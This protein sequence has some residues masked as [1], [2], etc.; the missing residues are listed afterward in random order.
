MGFDRQSARTGH[1][2]AADGSAIGS[3]RAEELLLSSCALCLV[4]PLPAFYVLTRERGFVSVILIQII[5]SF[6]L[7]LFSGPGPAAIAEI[8]P[9]RGRSTWMSS[10]YAL[11]VAIFGAFAPFVSQWLI[12]ATGSKMA[13][14]AYVMAAAAVS[15]VTIAGLQETAHQPLR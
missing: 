1:P 14:A 3:D 13:P 10:S 6:A 2:R 7:S 5:F 11:A 9:T 15:F 4:L 12:D 8:F